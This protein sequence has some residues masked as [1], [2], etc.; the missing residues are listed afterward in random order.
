MGK[1]L[2]NSG[3]PIEMAQKLLRHD[4]LSSTAIYYN[5]DFSLLQSTMQA[6]FSNQ[7][8]DVIKKN[9]ENLGQIADE[10]KAKKIMGVE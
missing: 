8:K 4:A 9:I 2:A 3:V 1:L 7:R 5:Q 10:I 6:L